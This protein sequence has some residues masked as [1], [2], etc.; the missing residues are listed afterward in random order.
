[1][2]RTRIAAAGVVLA[3]SVAFGAGIYIGVSERLQNIASAAQVT[4]PGTGISF[5]TP[6]AQPDK[7]DFTELWQV[8]NLLNDNFVQ[9]HAS[10]TIPTDKEKLYGIIAGLTD[11]YKDPYTVF[12]PPTDA[13]QFNEDI[14]GSFGGVGMELGARD[15]SLTVVSPLKGT[16]AAAADIRSGDIILAIDDKAAEHMAVDEAVKLIRGPVG[17]PV[18]ITVKRAGAAQPLT[19]KIVRQTIQIPILKS[20]TQGGTYVIELYSF[21]ENS[22]DL[23]RDALRQYFQSGSTKLVLDLRGNPGGYL[24]AAVQMASYFLPVGE[25]VVSEDFGGK[26]TNVVHRSLGY[27]VFANKKLSL[28]ILVDQGSASAAEILAG[29]LQSH[30]IGKLVGTRTFGKG[31]VQQ[32]IDLPD[33]AELKVTVAKWLTPDGKSISDG[34]LTPDIKADRT[35]DDVKAGRDPQKEAANAWLAT[36]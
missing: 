18:T 15:G 20:Y 9:T 28:A 21:S 23:F 12:L 19:I 17:T 13:K 4:I 11:S 24:D 2:N 10:N 29:A 6:D 7:V 27:N 34:G 14:A 33:G 31:S 36:Q 8:W 16:P 1:M 32:L 3:L 5:G 35:A 26:Q 22:V 30:G 25:S